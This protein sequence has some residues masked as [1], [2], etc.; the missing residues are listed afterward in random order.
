MKRIGKSLAALVLALVMSLTLLPVQAMAVEGDLTG[1]GGLKTVYTGECVNPLYADALGA[2]TSGWSQLKTSIQWVADV[3]TAA[4]EPYLTEAEAVKELQRQMIARE[5][6]ITINVRVPSDADLQKKIAAC[7]QD[8]LAHTSGNGSAGDYL[9]WQYAGYKWKASSS[10]GTDWKVTFTA[11]TGRPSIWYAKK[12]QEQQLTSYIQSTIL[13]QLALDGKTTYQKVK[14]IYDWITRNVRYDEKN[15]DDNSYYLKYTA[16]AAA[17]NKEAVCQ[18]YTNLFYRL[19]ND[20]GI[21]CRI[22]T[23]GNHAWNIV[24]MDDGKY[25]CMDATWDEGRSSYSYFLKGWPEF[26]KTHSPQT[27]SQNTPYWT[28]YE[29]KMSDTDY[30][31]APVV[32][33][34]TVP[35]NV[36]LVSAKAVSDGIQVKWQ[37]ADGAVRYRVYR[38]DAVNTKW[39]ALTSSATGTSYVDDTAKAGVKYSYT[40]RGIAADGKTLSPGFD[41]TGVSAVAAPANVKLGTAVAGKNGITVK[42]QA[43]D[44]AV[45]YR[46]YRKDAAN[47]GWKN[48]ATVNDTI[49]TDKTAVAGVTYTYT[50]RGIAADGKTLSPGFDETGVSAVAAPANVTLGT[51]VAG[52]NGITV[53]WKEAAGA[54]TYKVYRKDTTNT[55]WTVL[56]SSA[57]GTSYVDKTA[58]AGVTYTYTVRGIA[59]DGKT[60]SPS[61]DKTGVSAVAAPANVKLVGATVV[62]GGIQV[63]WQAAD[64]A[65]RYRVYRK[66]AANTKWKALTSSATGTGYTDKT[67]VAGVE[68]TYTVRGIASDGKTLSPSHEAGVSATIPVPANVKLVSAKA[69]SGGIQVTWKSAAGAKTY[70]VYRKDTTNTKWKALTSSATGASYTDKTAVVGVQYSYTV[71]GIAADG[72]TLSPSY[73]K[74]GV[75]ATAA[76]ANVTLGSAKAVNSGIQVTWQKAEDAAKYR[77][78]R[79]DAAN[80]NWKTIATVSGTSYTDKTA[81]I[82]TRYTYTVRGVASDGKTLSPGYDKTG[83]SATAT[84]ARVALVDAKRVTTGTKGIQVRWKSAANAQTYNVYRAANPPTDENGYPAAVTSG[85]KLVG[86]QVN[87]LSF[88]DT[89]GQS[90]VTYAY[91]VRGVAVDGKTLSATYNKDGV[92]ATMPK[93]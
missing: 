17:I 81:K 77:V 1:K 57:A 71:R 52:K 61:Y 19:A 54:K 91:T 68:Y 55:K 21:D 76:P 49:Y 36:K 74:T 75:S 44:G 84:P 14:A 62:S 58:K 13:P 70:K 87:G 18:G 37:A 51:A 85:W 89:T 12:E 60:L 46:V 92:R 65:V 16:Y 90:G 66:D 10:N 45:R 40:V 7:W 88:K 30:N 72:K 43:A 39:K 34:P 22:I 33:K 29:S 47:T 86:K 63:K 82:G 2:E 26:S 56:T 35:A 38:K 11:A 78:Y 32:P 8:A 6:S 67:A 20:A 15:K 41:E 4:D 80:T 3:Q 93:R 9:R 64:G 79:K 27:D 48:I 59:S 25:Y 69:V 23:G 73:D 24:R 83:V 28:A 50:V 42:W 5:E 53:T 31:A